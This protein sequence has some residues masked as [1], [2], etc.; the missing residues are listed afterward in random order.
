M[1]VDND[2]HKD[3][4]ELAC[5]SDEELLAA[6]ASGYNDA[7]TVLFSRHRTMVFRAGMKVLG[8][9]GEAE[10]LTQLV[11]LEIYRQAAKFDP[12]RGSGKAWILTIAYSRSVN[13]R[14]FL[15]RRSF[16]HCQPFDDIVHSHA[17][18]HRLPIANEEWSSLYERLNNA[19]HRLNENQRAVIHRVCFEGWTLREIAT[20]SGESFANV[21]HRY[22]RGLK[23]MR[24]LVSA[25]EP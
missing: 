20:E 3:G 8:D 18:L 10:D 25:T 24:T 1:E 2:E 14:E 6:I 15:L 11:F 4:R 12:K 17:A 19:L 22:Y 23:K 9:V 13:Q 21:R 5:S 7:L 16:Y